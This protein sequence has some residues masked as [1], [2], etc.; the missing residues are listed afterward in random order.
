MYS[1]LLDSFTYLLQIYFLLFVKYTWIKNELNPKWSLT[2]EETFIQYLSISFSM[3]IQKQKLT[4]LKCQL[5]LHKKY[6]AILKGWGKLRKIITTKVINY[7]LQSAIN[8]FHPLLN[9]HSHCDM[10]HT[11]LHRITLSF[12]KTWHV[13]GAH[14]IRSKQERTWNTNNQFVI[15][16]LYKIIAWRFS[17]KLIRDI[18][19][20]SWF[21][22]NL[23]FVFTQPFSQNSTVIYRH[24]YRIIH[25]TRHVHYEICTIPWKTICFH[26]RNVVNKY[27]KF[28]EWNL[29]SK[30]STANHQENTKNVKNIANVMLHK[31]KSNIWR[32]NGSSDFSLVDLDRNKRQTIN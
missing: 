23:R 7:S 3:I 28:I 16:M 17:V 8:H 4:H 27:N 11:C 15:E 9:A 25:M 31:I 30:F 2:K 21:V 32:N 20:G 5:H 18:N 13:I 1:P 6:S 24:L 10:L 14:C 19:T 29:W 26:E 12:W 22:I